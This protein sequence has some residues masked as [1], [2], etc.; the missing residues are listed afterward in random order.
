MMCRPFNCEQVD[1]HPAAGFALRNLPYP[2]V[3]P[4]RDA[5]GHWYLEPSSLPALLAPLMEK[6]LYF[7]KRLVATLVG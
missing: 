7:A 4:F 5:D 2:V 6:S 1:D 3:V